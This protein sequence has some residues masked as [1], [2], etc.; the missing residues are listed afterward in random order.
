MIELKGKHVV[1]TGASA[2]IGAELCRQLGA[3][4]C[5]VTLAARRR[6]LLNDVA[7]EVEHAGGQALVET[8][9]V[10]ERDEVFEL[11]DF[12]RQHFGEIDIWVSNAGTGMRHRLLDA[13]EADML[14]LYR[15]N[16]LS[17]LWAYQAVASRWLELGRG[18]QLIDVASIGAKSG[19]AYG[20]GYCA[21]KHGLSGMGDSLRQELGGT[22]IVLT[23]VYPG[24]TASE[25]HEALIDRTEGDRSMRTEVMSR[26]QPW[27]V[28][29][30]TQR[31]SS[32]HVARCIVRAM[33]RPVPT[34]YP[35]RWAALAALA[36][37]L[38]P[39]FLLKAINRARGRRV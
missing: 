35:H 30:I 25:F 12:A 8:C 33:E 4:G 18:G 13:T 34:V 5:R 31:Q 36:Y 6:A 10:I 24:L 29:Q 14:D 23:T 37:N 7:Q 22:G 19:F 3:A 11:A 16:C 39:G 21:A 9:D 15:L 27:I 32:A 38:S 20:G 26:R 28:R 1:V 2:G 17:S